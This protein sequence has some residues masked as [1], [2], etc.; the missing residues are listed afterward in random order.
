MALELS[1]MLDTRSDA[2]TYYLEGFDGP[3]ETWRGGQATL[4][5]G[6]LLADLQTATLSALHARLLLPQLLAASEYRTKCQ[7]SSS[8][9]GIYRAV[10]AQQLQA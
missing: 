6:V 7:Q 1:A 5:I 10:A 8:L 4:I 3:A 9:G 2:C